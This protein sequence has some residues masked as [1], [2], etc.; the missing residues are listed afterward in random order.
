MA[1]PVGQDSKGAGYFNKVAGLRRRIAMLCNILEEIINDPRESLIIVQ[2]S[3]FN[4]Q[5]QFFAYPL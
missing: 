5:G 2:T 3:G 4:H 1:M